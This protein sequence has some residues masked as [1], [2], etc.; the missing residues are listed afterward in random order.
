MRSFFNYTA[1]VVA[2]FTITTFSS[3]AFAVNVAQE[4]ADITIVIE[5]DGTAHVTDKILINV[6]NGPLTAMFVENMALTPTWGKAFADI[7]S[8]EQRIPLKINH[9]KSGKHYEL[10][11]DPKIPNGKAYMIFTYT[12]NM[13]DE[14]Y[15]GKTT[16]DTHGDLYYFHW[17]PIQWGTAMKYR[18]VKIVLP[19]EVPGEQ[20]D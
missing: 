3:D 1:A 14:G 16:S 15:I 18:D 17:A 10:E 7:V 2:A 9:I 8:T 13:I 4:T 5:S 6:T 12:G 19:L 11:A 20:I